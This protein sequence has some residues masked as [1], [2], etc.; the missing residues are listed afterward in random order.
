[1]KRIA[2]LTNFT[3]YDKKY[4]LCNVAA[5]QI[6]MLKK[7]NY[8]VIVIVN[9]GFKAEDPYTEDILRFIPNVRCYNEIKRDDTWEKDCDSLVIK[10]E[11]ILKDVD[12]VLSHDLIYQP[13][14]LKVNIAARKGAGKLPGIQWLH[15]IHSSTTPAM[16]HTSQDYLQ[17]V[18]TR[19]PNS[20]VIYP[21]SFEI[22][23]V[24]RNLGYEE[25]QIKVV[26]HA[27][28]P[29]EFFEFHP[30]TRK[31]VEDK[32]MYQADVIGCYPIRLDRGKQPEK[33]IKIFKAIKDIGRSIR[34]VICDF[35]STGGDK[36]TYRNELKEMGIQIGL[37][38]SELTFT[39]DISAECALGVPHTV[40][41]D[42]MLISNLFIMPSRSETYSLITQEAALCGNL[43][44]L[45]YDFPPMRS[46]YGAAPLY[47]K[48]SSNIDITSGFDGNTKTEYQPNFEAYA[49]DLALR[50]CYHLEHDRSLALR[51][52]IRKQ[53][54]NQ[55]I[56]KKQIEPLFY[57]SMDKW[58]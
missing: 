35:H 41:R 4:S 57:K 24:G 53:R 7:N 23:R 27:T 17:L 16:L 51:T 42:L 30:I 5:E 39:S 18:K 34:L 13:A 22:P 58:S 6:R 3:S 29:A 9:E 15:W 47:G 26:H 40:V 52:M 2:L 11:D 45:N 19:F 44:M 32:N 20:F 12:T 1:M 14:Y 54:N 37:T 55:A 28:E 10:L 49:H 46:I 48:F 8:P 31:L 50:I 33:A 36:V 43:L 56:F 25:D 38:S 21:N